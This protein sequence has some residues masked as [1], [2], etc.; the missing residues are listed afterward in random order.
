[1]RFIDWYG[2]LVL[3]EMKDSFNLMKK[4]KSV[5]FKSF[6]CFNFLGS[7]TKIEVC[8]FL[9]IKFAVL[10]ANFQYRYHMQTNVLFSCLE[11]QWSFYYCLDKIIRFRTECQNH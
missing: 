7:Q 2:I 1:M 3:K 10:G 6:I 11:L 9:E 8:E 4:L 5:I